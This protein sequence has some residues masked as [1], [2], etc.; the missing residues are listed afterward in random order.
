M[1]SQ[2]EEAAMSG[3]RRLGA[4]A[5]ATAVAVALIASPAAAG[6]RHASATFVDASGATVGWA[7]LVEDAAGVVHVNVHVEGLSAGLHGI[8][9]HSIGAC[10]PFSAAGGHYNP[11]GHQHGLDNPFGP[12]AGDLPN[13][14]VN[15]N[16]NGHLAATTDRVT[17]S[18]GPATLFDSTAGAVGS[19]FII[20]ANPDN[21]LTNADNGASGGRIACAVIES[22]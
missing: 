13:L 20:H 1:T 7:K 9:I 16:G 17:L 12:H 21:Q 19:A 6:A 15:A 11:A 5:A 10:S 3:P 2:S 18:D 14:V 22:D 8:H 4:V